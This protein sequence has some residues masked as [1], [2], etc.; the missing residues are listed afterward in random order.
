MKLKETRIGVSVNTLN[1]EHSGVFIVSQSLCPGRFVVPVTGAFFLGLAH[2]LC[3][4]T[5]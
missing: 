2:R 5:E 1:R 3:L 4:T